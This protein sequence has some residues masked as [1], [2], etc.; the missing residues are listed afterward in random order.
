MKY[1]IN[2]YLFFT[3]NLLFFLPVQMVKAED[4]FNNYSFEKYQ[5]SN[6]AQSKTNDF[7]FD[8][9]EGQAKSRVEH[10]LINYLLGQTVDQYLDFGVDDEAASKSTSRLKLRLKRHRLML[11][12]RVNLNL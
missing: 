9:S 5:T 2:I 3:A 8:L 7:D 12:Y 10:S 4:Y 11:I 1:A 6:L